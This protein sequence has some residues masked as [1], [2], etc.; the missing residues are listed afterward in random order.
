MRV[1]PLPKRWLIHDIVYEEKLP[2]K[3][4]YGN[5]RYATP[6]IIKYVRFDNETV[7]SRD[8]T[9]TKI[10]ANAVI[11]VDAT[12]STNL[13]EKFVEQSKITFNNK[14][15]TLK[16]VIEAFHPIKNEIH[17]YELEVV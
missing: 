3:D 12:H 15:Y 17:H 4:S 8:T 5:D 13:P 7:F 14:V 1:R 11:Y 10:V 16:K 2:G 9:D 6:V